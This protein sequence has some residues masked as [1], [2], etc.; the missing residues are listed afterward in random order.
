[1][2]GQLTVR[3]LTRQDYGEWLPLW[4]GYNAFYGRS[5]PTA[6]AGEIT[7]MTWSRFF[8]AYEPV[9]ALVAECDGKLQG[10]V[11]Y[12]YH[13]S[14]TSIVPSCYLQDLF[15]TKAARGRG[16]GRALIEGVYERARQAGAN[17]VYWL[18]HETNHTAMQLY[19]RI[20]ERSGFVVYRKMF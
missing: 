8:D 2:S 12:L 6:L 10:L 5:G 3:P 16:V 19:D 11:H 1:M 13:R 7:Q 17:R 9:H 14:T 4:D 15:T 20:G 18:T